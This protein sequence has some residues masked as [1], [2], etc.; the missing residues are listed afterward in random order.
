MIEQT[1]DYALFLLDPSGRI[2]SWNLGAERLKGYTA[3]EIIGRHFSVFYTREAL[4][5]GW[6]AHELQVATVEARFED[7]GWRVRKD[8]SRF[9]A[10][11]VITALRD[12]EGKLVGFSKITRD[13]SER[14]LHELAMRQSE[15]RFRLLV[16]A[17]QDYAI[18]MIDT[19]G[20]VTSWNAGAQR[21]KGYSREEIIGRHFSHFFTQE[22]ITAGKPWEELAS[23]RRTGRAEMEG[24]RVKKNGE[25]FW[26]RVILTGVY[27]DQGHL[28]GFAKVTQDLSERRHIQDLEKAARNVNEF[29]AMLAHE[30]R[31]PLA[32][33]R[34][35]VEVIAKS[36]D[37]PVT[38]EA[39]RQTIDRQSAQLARIVDDMIDIAR[40]TK[41]SLVIDHQPVELA[42]IVRRALETAAPAIN[43][44][45]HALEVD[46]PSTGLVAHGDCDRL[47]QLLSNLLNNAAR[48]TPPGG[49]ISVRA[50]REDGHGIITVRDTG[51]GIDPQVM[52]R[53]FDM[54]VQGRSPLERVGGGLGI[55]LAL[56]RRI[57]ELHG[58]TLEAKS[59]GE[60]KGSEFIVRLPLS[61]ASQVPAQAMDGAPVPAAVPR[62]V[63]V[64]DD[65]V[66]AAATLELLLR[67]LGHETCVAHDGMKA[68][69]IAR[70]FRPEVILLDIGMPGLDGYEVA[71][72]LR[73]M[74]QGTSFRIIAV[75]G[76]GQDGDRSKA[77]D[78]GFDVHLVKPVDLGVLAKVL[79]DRNGATLH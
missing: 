9:W 50:R 77:K 73:A 71:R 32:P 55:G 46:V 31:N 19:E 18:F 53:I 15:E 4:D 72:R 17:V 38:R 78:A 24:W 49:R 61:P 67:S 48:Y 26:A 76:W 12:E 41:G 75:T 25:R 69:D 21:I 1:R 70:E 23:A 52:E 59:E 40:I 63:L 57:A 16:D 68:L 65:N 64:V 66:D 79:D 34:T 39:M 6:P 44:A 14:R 33:I 5:S 28:R 42:E 30:L 47:T 51:R 8:G 27:D 10:N 29:I 35:A 2:I 7:E 36:P 74:N 62:R 37:D 60:N 45:R 13:L 3:D 56:A 22:D 11:V 20:M 54:F 58:G 43:A